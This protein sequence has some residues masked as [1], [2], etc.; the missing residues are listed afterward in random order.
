[1]D[2]VPIGQNLYLLVKELSAE[3]GLHQVEHHLYNHS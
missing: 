1:M 2:L 3:C